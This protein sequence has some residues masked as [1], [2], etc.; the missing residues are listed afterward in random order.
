MTAVD[1]SKDPSEKAEELTKPHRP[2]PF[3]LV[4]HGVTLVTN[5]CGLSPV[6]FPIV[7]L[8][9]FGGSYVYCH[10]DNAYSR[11]ILIGIVALV[12]YYF[13]IACF[14]VFVYNRYLD[15][16]LEI[17]GPKACPAHGANLT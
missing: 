6:S 7:V 14:R 13:L 5:L 12:S 15:P 8:L 3:I 17:P 1:P 4:L 11:P 2:S 16:L 10:I 9:S